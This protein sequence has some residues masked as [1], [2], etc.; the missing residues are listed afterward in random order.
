MPLVTTGTPEETQGDEVKNGIDGPNKKQA[1]ES[2]RG[3]TDT[4]TLRASNKHL[5]RQRASGKHNLRAVYI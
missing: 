3:M 5:E 1:Q 2:L 4:P